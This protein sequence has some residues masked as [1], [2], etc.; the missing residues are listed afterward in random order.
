MWVGLNRD[1]DATY[2]FAEIAVAIMRGAILGIPHK[3]ST[4]YTDYADS[5]RKWV[6]STV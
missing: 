3:S 4:D 2:R 1:F 6:E 5:R